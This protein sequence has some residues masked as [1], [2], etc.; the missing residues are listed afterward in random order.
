M[1]EQKQ[2]DEPDQFSNTEA[3]RFLALLS[4][5]TEKL[6]EICDHHLQRT[7][8]NRMIFSV[9]A[10]FLS[11]IVIFS[12]PQIDFTQLLRSEFSLLLAS[13][14]G[15]IIM[16]SSVIIIRRSST[17]HMT[18]EA[19]QVAITLQKLVELASQLEEN[20]RYRFSDRVELDFRLADAEASL[21]TYRLI[22]MPKYYRKHHSS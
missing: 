21:V 14:T 22:F 5:Y 20:S 7:Q 12:I 9:I 10:S 16:C 4:E 3:N 13:L 15:I 2:F 17:Q 19:R 6:R 1:A 8:L 18:H 11:F